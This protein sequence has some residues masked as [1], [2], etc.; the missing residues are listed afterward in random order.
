MRP[1]LHKYRRNPSRK[2]QAKG[3]YC[4]HTVKFQV[5]DETI[6]AHIQEKSFKKGTGKR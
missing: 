5:D 3:K 4:K 2:A 6:A 1:L